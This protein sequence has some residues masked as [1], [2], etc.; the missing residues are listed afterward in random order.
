MLKSRSKQYN[1]SNLG[2]CFFPSSFSSSILTNVVPCLV[3]SHLILHS[4]G[5]RWCRHLCRCKRHWPSNHP[6]RYKHT[7]KNRILQI[8][9]VSCYVD[10][11]PY[12]FFSDRRD[13]TLLEIMLLDNGS[14]LYRVATRSSLQTDRTLL[15]STLQCGRSSSMA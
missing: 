11:H 7:S 2:I 15:R 13:S 3:Y 1:L 4:F 10:T 5:Q 14:S 6:K 8:S 12:H 9:F